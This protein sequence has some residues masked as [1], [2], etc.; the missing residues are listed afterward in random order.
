MKT[1]VSALLLGASLTLA[2]A[3][4]YT[5]NLTPGQDGGGARTG[6]GGGLIT[7]SGNTLSINGAFSGISGNWTADHIHGP[8]APGINANVLY[9]LQTP[10]TTLNADQ[11]SGTIIGSFSL[12][13]NPGNPPS[14]FTIAQQLS[15]LDSGLWYVNIHSQTFGGGEIRGQILPVPEPSTLA[16]IALSIG[17]GGWYIRRRRS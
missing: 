15:Q 3:Q 14:G 6:S 1:L 10:Y 17:A 5:F 13:D 11:R 9:G 16:L 4:N 2:Q 12:V 8:G 7:L